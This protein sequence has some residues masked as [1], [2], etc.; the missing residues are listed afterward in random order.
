VLG[1]Y[2]T[3]LGL[4]QFALAAFETSRDVTVPT[5]TSTSLAPGETTTTSLEPGATTSTTTAISGGTT[6]TA[7]LPGAQEVCGNCRDDDGDGLVD[8]EDPGCCPGGTAAM[9]LK[10]LGIAAGKKGTKL[11]LSGTLAESGVAPGTAATQDVFLQVATAGQQ[12]LC[13]HVPAANLKR[14]K[15]RLRFTDAA[16]SVVSAAS[17]ER[18]RLRAKKDG[19]G[20][21]AAGSKAMPFTVPSAGP[22]VVTLG[23]RDPAAAEGGN[24]CARAQAALEASKKGALRLP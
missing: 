1:G 9:T 15:S 7:Q 21:L 10:K 22:A 8:F 11:A 18:L 2:A 5:T 24:R 6:T 3:I 13:A 20:A 16:H 19:S 4:R 12:L 17:L 23:L 14:K